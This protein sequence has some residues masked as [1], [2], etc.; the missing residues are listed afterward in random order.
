MVST[1]Y[2][3]LALTL[4]D[5]EGLGCPVLHAH[6]DMTDAAAA[7]VACSH[8]RVGRCHQL[9]GRPIPP[10]QTVGRQKGERP[11]GANRRSV[12]LVASARLGVEVN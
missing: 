2:G 3:T 6:A 1:G 12:M 11:L 8:S 9:N 10:P 5:P 4:A 7:A